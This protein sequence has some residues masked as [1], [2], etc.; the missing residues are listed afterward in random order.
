MKILN[1]RYLGNW[2]NLPQIAPEIRTLSFSEILRC[3]IVFISF[4]LLFLSLRTNWFDVPFPEGI[5]SHYE[6]IGGTSPRYQIEFQGILA[7]GTVL[8]FVLGL[9]WKKF[10]I[11]HT[12]LSLAMLL[13][14]L[15]FPY[16]VMFQNPEFSAEATW[17]QIQHDHLTWL[18]GDI[19]LQAEA[20]GNAWMAKSYLSDPP[21]ILSVAPLPTWSAW[22]VGLD[23]IEDVLVWCGYSNVFCQFARR[24]WFFACTGSALLCMASVLPNGNLDFKRMGAGLTFG[25]TFGLILIITAL[26]GPFSAKKHLH[27][28]TEAIRENNYQKALVSLELCAESF[29]VLT[30]DTNFIRQKG[31]LEHRLGKLSDF[32]LLHQAHCLEMDRK[33]NQSFDIWKRLTL[34]KRS[35]IRRESLRAVLRFAINDYNSHR[36][37][38]AKN[39]FYFV[40][41][42][43]P[44]SPNIVYYLQVIGVREGKAREVFY[45]CRWMKEIN[46]HLNFKSTKILN[47]VSQQNAMLAAA[48][49]NDQNETWARMIEAR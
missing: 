33:L 46:R 14:V 4:F 37:T 11:F 16:W 21:G 26:Q 15:I 48:A 23:K 45:L 18:G 6:M 30:Q 25:S 19:S 39:R 27:A 22:D 20:S 34:S 42:R 49:K 35:E 8:A 44:A 10:T 3:F 13:V 43:Q 47:A 36:L 32:A 2:G 29:P 28:S 17:L 1:F 12:F 40:L 31:L 9:L 41:K 7:F 5:V 24:G 38:K